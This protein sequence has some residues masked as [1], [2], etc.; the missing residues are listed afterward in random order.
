[1]KPAS[2][3]TDFLADLDVPHTRQYSDECFADM[4]FRSL[5]GFSKLLESY[6]IPN[7]ALDLPDKANDIHKLPVPFLARVGDSF[8]IV[9]EVAS[10]FVVI[11]D[12]VSDTSRSLPINK[13]ME[14][15]SGVVLVAY[16]T[17]SSAEPC[18]CKHHLID[19]AQRAKRWVLLAAAAF[20]FVY[21]FISNGI[22]AH[23][24]T[25]FLT[26]IF[27][28][29]LYVT[30][31]LVLKSLN[32]HSDAG[33][34]ICGLIDRT[35]CHTVLSTKAS[36]FFGL[37]GWSEV[38]FAYFSV[39]LGCLLVFPQYL[40]YLALINACCCPFSIWSVWYQKYRAKA[41]CTLCLITQGCL[42]GALI[43]FL[44]GG[45]FRGAFPLYIEFFVLCASY[46]A[47]LLAINAVTPL[48]DHNIKKP[49]E[50]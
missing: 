21:L 22:Y 34:S 10:N 11:D 27:G 44:A 19:T 35:G 5:F 9:R 37:F 1:M 29:G 40:P 43:C 16:P 30:Y 25:V 46:V 20:I 7:E 28:A 47:A 17:H 12:G 32:I 48:F 38:G 8:V 24:S 39:S 50:K 2:I 13:F 6:G 3:F 18:Y 49:E 26:L 14:K 4:T 15:W 31:E 41:W 23:V 45:W 36:T 42:W 33:D